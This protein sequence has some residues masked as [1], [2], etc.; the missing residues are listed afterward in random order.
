MNNIK[1]PTNRNFGIVFFLFFLIIALW[2]L[3]GGYELR[4]WSLGI[5]FIFLILG[6]I[7]SKYLSPLNKLWFKFGLMLGSIFAPIVMFLI[8]F[9]IVTPIGLFMRVLGK[10]ILRLKKRDKT[11][12]INKKIYDKSS[13]NNQF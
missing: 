12:W 9:L 2:P 4:V 1:L 3:L 8:F 13:M 7:N 5:S 6:I 11:Y 10:D